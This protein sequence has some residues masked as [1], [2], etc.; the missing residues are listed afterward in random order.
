[1]LRKL[2]SIQIINRIEPIAGADK[3]ELAT[4]LNWNCVVK[5]DEFKVGDKVVY[6]EIDSYLPVRPEFE[7]LRKS[8][9]KAFPNGIE[10]FRLRTCKLKGQISCGLLLPLDIIKSTKMKILGPT[11][12]SIGS[13]VSKVLGIEKYEPEL[14]GQSHLRQPWIIRKFY[15]VKW[16]V[17][18]LFMSK[19]Q[20]KKH[21]GSFPSF[22][23]K[24]DEERIQNLGVNKF[25]GQVYEESEKADGTSS[26]YYY[27]KGEFGVCSRNNKLGL[28]LDDKGEPT[29]KIFNGAHWKIAKRYNIEENLTK[30][31]IERKLNLAIQGELVGPGIQ[32]NKYN[33]ADYDFFVFKI[34]DIDNNKFLSSELRESLCKEL[35]LKHVPILERAKTFEFNNVEEVLAYAEGKSV[36]CPTA[37]REGIVFKAIDGSHSFKAISNKFLL[38]YEE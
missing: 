20:K 19:E 35:G 28:V 30:L 23:R 26:T 11:A 27:N 17:T 29:G 33:L 21:G 12:Y 32:K 2:A 38:K 7:F 36:I 6:V 31:C 24:T 37:E 18:S 9:Y 22:V 15:Q 14:L 34:F 25:K 4:V 13:D 8:S 5:K 10:G 1:M 3:I 16:F